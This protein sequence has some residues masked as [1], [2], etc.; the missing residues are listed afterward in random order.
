MRVDLTQAVGTI[1]I[2]AL[3]LAELMPS[4]ETESGYLRLIVGP[5]GSD[6]NHRQRNISITCSID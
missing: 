3:A 2:G 1:N 4:V 6:P 5:T